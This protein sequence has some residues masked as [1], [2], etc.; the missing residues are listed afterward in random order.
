VAQLTW[1]G[2]EHMGGWR[3][4]GSVLLGDKLLLFVHSWSQ[5]RRSG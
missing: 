3:R 5:Q 1:S 4:V 2:V